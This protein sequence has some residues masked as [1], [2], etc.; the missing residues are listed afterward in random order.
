M[1]KGVYLCFIDY[2]KVFNMVEH[3][4]QFE[5]IG[6]LDLFEKNIYS[7]NILLVYG[8]KKNSINI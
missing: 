7:E 2:G 6:K 4:D 8:L 1:Q 5:T 3:I